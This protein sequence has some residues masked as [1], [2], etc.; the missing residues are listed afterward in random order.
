MAAAETSGSGKLRSDLMPEMSES[1]R[2]GVRRGDERMRSKASFLHTAEAGAATIS[3]TAVL[4]MT[5][6]SRPAADCCKAC[7]RAPDCRRASFDRRS[8]WIWA[9]RM[10]IFGGI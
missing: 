2:F 10:S 8:A 1:H 6:V 7:R 4:A 3:S 9:N 5:E